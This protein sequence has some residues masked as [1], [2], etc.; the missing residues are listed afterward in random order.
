MKRKKKSNPMKAKMKT[1]L[2]ST[3]PNKRTTIARSSP[4]PKKASKPKSP[5]KYKGLDRFVTDL[6]FV[7]KARPEDYDD[8]NRQMIDLIIKHRI[9]TDADLK[10]FFERTLAV[11]G[12]LNRRKL[13]N[14]FI[15]IKRELD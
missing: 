7:D 8:L 1:K 10:S 3:K 12:H 5:K 2:R 4:S 13:Q 14:L 6:P 15:E 11:N 9:L